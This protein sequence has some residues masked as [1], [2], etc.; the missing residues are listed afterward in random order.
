MKIGVISLGCPKNT[1]D[2]EVMLSCL[3]APELT[4]D[5]K[6]ADYIIINTCGFIKQAREE[7]EAEIKKALKT[8][9]RVIV[10]GC[11][12]TKD[13]KYLKKK[14]PGV[15]AWTGVNDVE[16]VKK[17]VQKGGVYKSLRPYIYSHKKHT[18]LL[19]PYAVYIKVSEGCNHRCSFCTI[20]FIKGKY[21]S[22]SISDIVKEVKMLAGAGAKEINLIS[23]D[24]VYYGRDKGGK[25]KLPRLLSSILRNVKGDFWLR[26]LYLYPDFEVIKKVSKIMNKDRRLVRYMD[27]PFQHISTR[28]LRSM[29]R[30][31]GKSEILKITGF[32]RGNVK[33]ITIRSAFIAGYPGETKNDFNE[34]LEFIKSGAIDRP[35]IFEYSDEPGTAGFKLKNKVPAKERKKRYKRLTLASARVCHYNDMKQNKT[36]KKALITGNHGKGIYTA[37]TESMAPDIDGYVVIRPAKKMKLGTFAKIKIN[38]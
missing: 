18:A 14:Y 30:G 12:V 8:R 9:A 35:G 23:Q 31:H 36:A 27:I 15:F 26:L 1:V 2:T 29:R 4:R 13:L 37:R 10:S 16:A 38:N 34:L 7:S 5:P 28:V 6:K 24:V 32:L 20:P 3:G 22:R 17:A 11:Y 19:N 21:R 25:P 33:G